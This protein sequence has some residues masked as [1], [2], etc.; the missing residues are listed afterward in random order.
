MRQIEIKA[1]Y[2]SYDLLNA[3]EERT[4]QVHSVYPS[5]FNLG[6]GDFLSFIGNKNG[7]RLP[8]GV[9]LPRE[10]LDRLGAAEIAR[11][12]PFRWD[13]KTGCLYNRNMRIMLREA[14]VYRSGLSWY[15]VN[16]KG[17][18]KALRLLEPMAQGSSN[19]EDP[20]AA[21]FYDAA[22]KDGEDGIRLFLRHYLGR[23][24]GL[25]PSGD[26]MILGILLSDMAFGGGES[27]FRTELIGQL[28]Q[29]ITTDTSL[30]NFEAALK[31]LY[32]SS[33]LKLV[34]SIAEDD[35][36]MMEEAAESVLG[37]GH[38]S[39][40]DMLY[41]IFYHLSQLSMIV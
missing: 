31:G 15:Q 36:K 25:T 10:G 28:K 17:I 13:A 32:S 20:C 23:G 21:V 34:Q 11:G 12:A 5:G 2:V 19:S 6:L 8:F 7:E 16:K 1:Q 14:E 22:I 18:E 29:G 35:E 4:Y 9:L 40:K 37:F 30:S 27:A 3:L 26:D 24:Q 33:L 39:G 41:G 38:S